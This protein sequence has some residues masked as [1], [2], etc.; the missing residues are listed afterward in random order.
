VTGLADPDHRIAH[1]LPTRPEGDPAAKGH[2]TDVQ[3]VGTGLEIALRNRLIEPTLK[4]C[5]LC[6]DLEGPPL[7][8]A[9]APILKLKRKPSRT[10]AGVPW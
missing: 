2:V 8:C 10:S 3:S 4:S 1:G 6:A 7:T 9:N 5:G